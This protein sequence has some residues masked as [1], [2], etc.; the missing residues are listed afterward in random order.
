M[1]QSQHDIVNAVLLLGAPEPGK[2]GRF[3]GKYS[4]II[5]PA[6]KE[7]P[8][9]VKIALGG[10]TSS[11]KTTLLNSMF[12][13]NI[14]SVT[15]EEATGVPVEVQS[16]DQVCVEVFAQNGVLKDKLLVKSRCYQAVMPI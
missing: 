4:G 14:F 3:M 13:T 15:Q 1:A 12:Q 10:E 7:V 6:K 9:P 5:F 16:G 11:G 2:K 8:I